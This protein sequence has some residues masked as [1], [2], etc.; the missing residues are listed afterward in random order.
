MLRLSNHFK[1]N[2][3]IRVGRV[4]SADKMRRVL[5]QSVR[6]QKG[7]QIYGRGAWIKTMSIYW[8]PELHVIITVDHYKNTVVS[9]Y[10]EDMGGRRPIGDGLEEFSYGTM[11]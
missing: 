1:D 6:I 11:Q 2:W 5:R 4:P 9:V 8:H 3:R 7:K 10:S